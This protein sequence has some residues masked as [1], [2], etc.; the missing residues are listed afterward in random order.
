M[1]VIKPALGKPIVLWKCTIDGYLLNSRIEYF[2]VDN[3]FIWFFGRKE[4]ENTNTF[5][6]VISHSPTYE[7]PSM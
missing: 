4:V 2:E 5:Y 1:G 7:L 6:V 3:L